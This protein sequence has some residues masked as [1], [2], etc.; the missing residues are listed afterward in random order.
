MLLKLDG[1]SINDIYITLGTI[2]KLSKEWET[3]I[4]TPIGVTKTSDDYRIVGYLM[5]EFELD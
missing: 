4:A 3:G 1:G 5:R 2:Y